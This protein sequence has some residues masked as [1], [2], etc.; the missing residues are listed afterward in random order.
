MILITQLVHLAP[1]SS[2]LVI[3]P[4]DQRPKSFDYGFTY[5]FIFIRY[6]ILNIDT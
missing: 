5:F 4:I 1:I 6:F 2:T 3:L